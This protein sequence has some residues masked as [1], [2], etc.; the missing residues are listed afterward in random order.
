[1]ADDKAKPPEEAG[2][3]EAT[4][5]SASEALANVPLDLTKDDVTAGGGAPAPPATIPYDPEPGRDKVRGYLAMWL[6]ALLS[7]IL[8]FSFCF[9]WRNPTDI[10]SLKTLL[11]VLFAPIITLVGTATGYYFGAAANRSPSK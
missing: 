7:V 3:A 8:L 1:M 4:P 2:N 11:D 9:F 5:A 10:A 6:L